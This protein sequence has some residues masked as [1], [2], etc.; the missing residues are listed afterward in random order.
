MPPKWGMAHPQSRVDCCGHRCLY[1]EMK[2]CRVPRMFPSIPTHRPWSMKRDKPFSL[3]A[4]IFN[5]CTITARKFAC[6]LFTMPPRS[7]VDEHK[8]E[9]RWFVLSL[10]A[11]TRQLFEKCQDRG[12]KRPHRN[13]PCPVHRHWSTKRTN[14]RTI[15]ARNL[16]RSFWGIDGSV[17]AF[18]SVVCV[19]RTVCTSDSIESHGWNER[20]VCAQ[21]CS[22]WRWQQVHVRRIVLCGVDPPNRWP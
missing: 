21:C 9:S 17:D 12:K 1:W 7:P 22:G 20:E 3:V 10:S 6:S 5:K 8:L 14:H 18:A 16:A 19:H 15:T 11:T 2:E 13:V 4:A